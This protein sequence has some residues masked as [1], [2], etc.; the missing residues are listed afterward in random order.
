MKRIV[1]DVMTRRVVTVD[2]LAPY[3]GVVRLMQENGVSA[4]PV[5]DDDGTMLGIVSEGDLIL[6][7]DPELGRRGRLFDGR[8]RSSAR[9]KAA[10]SK[11]WELMTTPVVSVTPQASLGEAAR[12]MHRHAV[13]RLPVLDE[14]GRIVGI[15]SRVDL[16]EIFLRSDAEIAQE[17][18]ED[19]IR[20]T[21]WM[22]PDT[23]RAVVHD[24]V[25]TLQGQVERRSLISVV[26]RLVSSVEGVVGVDD[27]L[28]YL[29]DDGSKGDYLT[30]WASLTPKAGR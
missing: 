24:G 22:E 25:V 27:Q 8:G 20:R 28:S 3:K 19:V 21:L 11:A 15:V 29:H 4:L 5:V 30:P 1:A 13:K 16:L 2:A 23:I 9:A 10:A 18:R 7:E 6:K 12:L 14:G 26:D 17:I